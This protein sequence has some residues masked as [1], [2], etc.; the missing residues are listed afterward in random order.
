MSRPRTRRALRLAFV[1]GAALLA[2]A[3]CADRTALL[4]REI[5]ELRRKLAAARH[6]RDEAKA[7]VEELHNQVMILEDRLAAHAAN[8]KDEPKRPQVITV[9]PAPAPEPTR[10]EGAVVDPDDPDVEYDGAARDTRSPRPV[11]RI[12]GPYARRGVAAD[13]EVEPKE[14]R[15][16]R[17]GR[18]PVAQRRTPPS[19]DGERLPVVPL[20]DAGVPAKP[21]P[22]G[23]AKAAPPPAASKASPLAIYQKS[24]DAL[25]RKEHA[26]AIAGF[27][28]LIKSHPKHALAENARYW[29]GEAYYDQKNY[30]AALAEFRKLV[31]EHAGGHKAADALLKAGYCHQ[32]LG[33][34]KSARNLLGQVVELYPKSTAAKLAAE[35]LRE[36]R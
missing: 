17:Q 31:R 6:E 7:K 29:T 35:R 36:L 24:L 27:R 30:T 9:R 5:T 20:P 10:R 26:E 3:G 16:A 32:K 12:D 8:P 25:R 14:P 13:T 18:R 19:A 15:P 34:Q 21:V 28:D 33:D 23:T 4:Q 22:P 1:G 2:L 11:L